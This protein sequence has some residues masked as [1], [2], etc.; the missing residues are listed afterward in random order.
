[1]I[2]CALLHFLPWGIHWE[3]DMEPL[4]DQM[5]QVIVSLVIM[6]THFYISL[7]VYKVMIAVQQSRK[8]WTINFIGHLKCVNYSKWQCTF[9]AAKSNVRSISPSDQLS[10]T[11]REWCLMKESFNEYIINS[12]I[13][14][15][16]A[17][18]TILWRHGADW[19]ANRI[20]RI[21]RQ[22]HGPIDQ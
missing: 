5:L 2:S 14:K 17:I 1:M 18:A 19:S 12:T 10:D 7:L 20:V 9:F 16:S 4:D 13:F 6:R 22:F 3:V 21:V 11:L 15:H 8:V